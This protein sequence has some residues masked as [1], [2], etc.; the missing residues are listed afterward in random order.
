MSDVKAKNLDRYGYPPLEWARAVA[1]LEDTSKH[2][3]C[4]LAT[5]DP[6]GSAHI[7]GVGALWV[8]DKMYFT[9]S[10][11]ARKSRNVTAQPRC[12]MSVAGGDI[13][14]VI[15]GAAA[16]VTDDV[17]LQDL[18]ARYNAQGWPAR[19]E[20]GALTAEYSAPSAGPPPWELYEITPSTV[21]GVATAEPYGATR[22]QL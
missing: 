3:T 21:Y 20:N 4:W 12:A 6:D 14:L 2:R 15:E 8:N 19:A 18:A 7:A 22:W 13:D 5:T 9:S 1:A 10:P 17:T 11:R 16:R